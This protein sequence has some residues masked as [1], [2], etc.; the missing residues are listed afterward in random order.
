MQY[1]PTVV[2]WFNLRRFSLACGEFKYINPLLIDILNEPQI[3]LL[4]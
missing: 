1:V 3:L 4:M 2:A